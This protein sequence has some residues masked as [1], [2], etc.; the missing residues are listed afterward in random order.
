MACPLRIAVVAGSALIAFL[1]LYLTFWQS[2]PDEL[3]KDA[4]E[5]ESEDEA[6]N[7][8]R[9][10]SVQVKPLL[11]RIKSLSPREIL[12]EGALF[13]RRFSP[14]SL[15]WIGAVHVV[16]LS[17]VY[18]LFSNDSSNELENMSSMVGHEA[19][20]LAVGGD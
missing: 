6:E 5:A 10:E 7:E 14:I 18:Y 8:T 9:K 17:A 1:A 20:A 13:H 15:L 2:E 3:E 19:E 4:L 12:L 11:Q 16:V